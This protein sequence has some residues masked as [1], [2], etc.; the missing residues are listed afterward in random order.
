MKDKPHLQKQGRFFA[1][2]DRPAEKR[3]NRRAETTL[4]RRTKPFPFGGYNNEC[5][6]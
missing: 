1:R 3:Y 5:T 4:E 6:L 2:I